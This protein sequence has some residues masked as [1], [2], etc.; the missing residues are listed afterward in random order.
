M[1]TVIGKRGKPSRACRVEDKSVVR[2]RGAL[3]AHGALCRRIGWAVNGCH[4]AGLPMSHTRQCLPA[5]C[6]ACLHPAILARAH[7]TPGNACP[8]I[9]L[10]GQ[11]NACSPCPSASLSVICPTTAYYKTYALS[12]KKSYIICY[13]L[14]YQTA[15]P[16]A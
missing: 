3:G 9:G 14:Q 11:S 10:T 15:Q 16:S 13:V 4:T 5:R 6:N 1:G 12:C 7:C 8:Q 2:H